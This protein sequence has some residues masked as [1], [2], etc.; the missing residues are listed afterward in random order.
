V[1][2]AGIGVEL[3]MTELREKPAVK[4]FEDLWVRRQARVSAGHAHE[5][6]PYVSASARDFGIRDQVRRAGISV[7]NNVTEGF[8]RDADANFARFLRIA[9]ERCRQARESTS[10]IAALVGRLRASV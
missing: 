4:C 8:E 5:D 3:G 7:L 1:G 2:S 9:K 10:E 6:G